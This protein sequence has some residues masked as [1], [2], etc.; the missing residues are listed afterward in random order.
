VIDKDLVKITYYKASG[1]GGQHRNKTMSGVRLQ[2]EGHTIECCEGRDQRKNKELAYKRLYDKLV[3]NIDAKAIV[4]KRQQHQAQNA[5]CGK[6]GSYLRTYDF[7]RGIAE[8]DGRQYNL[9]K[10]MRGDLSDIYEN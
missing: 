8:Q 4:N 9:K 6:R 3:A 2:Y 5:Q 10:I 7:N 1:A